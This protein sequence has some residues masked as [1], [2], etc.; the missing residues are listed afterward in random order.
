[1][2]SKVL[3]AGQEGMV[4]R[5]LHNLFKKENNKFIILKC[6]RKD[7][8]FTDQFSVDKW[9]KKNRPNIVIN[10]AG[11][12]GGIMDNS[13]HQSDY[14]YINTMIGLNIINSSLKYNVGQLINLGSAC[15]YPRNS[16]QPINEKSLLSSA[17]EKT[18]EGYALA[19]ILSLK[20]CQHLKIKKKKNF[21]SLMP[22]NLYG[23]GDNFDLQSSHVLPALVKKFVIAKKKNLKKVEIWGSGRVKR[24]FLHV[25]DLS[26]SILFLINK[27]I[28][29]DYI[30]IGSGQ[31]F[32]I[33]RIANLLKKITKFKGKIFYNKKYPEGVKKR[34]LDSKTIYNLGWRP[35]ISLE[36][37][38]ENYCKYYETTIFPFESN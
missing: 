34:L 5:S 6:K 25:D 10:A 24:E 23:E 30:N 37:G 38:L 12:V 3:I 16:S 29:H 15:I 9:F 27:K 36:R 18:N 26:E 19:K 22:A 8:D 31:H 32:S 35:K 20:Y 2:K 28:S 21:I 14:I 1:L 17:L 7:L 11:K 13:R 4:G 33:K